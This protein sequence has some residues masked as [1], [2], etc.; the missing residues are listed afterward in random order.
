MSDCSTDLRLVILEYACLTLLLSMLVG[1]FFISGSV[2]AL[3]TVVVA[4]VSNFVVVVE[5]SVV[6]VVA[7]SSRNEDMQQVNEMHPTVV[8]L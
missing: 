1:S 6:F 2:S 4:S 8:L 5:A 3:A 7:S